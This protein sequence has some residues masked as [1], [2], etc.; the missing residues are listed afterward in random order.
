MA[1]GVEVQLFDAA[2]AA[3]ASATGLQ[4]A[5][6][7]TENVSDLSRVS[8][9]HAGATT[10]AS[11]WLRLDL[12]NQT[13]LALTQ[14]G[15]LVVYSLNAT[16]HKNSLVFA[17]K[18]QI[19]DV[20]G[21]TSTT[22]IDP[23]VRPADWLTMPTLN[24]GD[25]K[26]VGLLAV[27]ESNANFVALTCSGNYVVNW[28]DGSGDINVAAGV[29]AERN[30]QWANVGAG[31]LTSRGYRQALVTVTMQAGQTM[32]SFSLQQKHS[33][34][35]LPTTPNVAWLDC[36][37][38]APSLATLAVRTTTNVVTLNNLEVF[39]LLE[40][41]VT[42]FTSMFQFCYSLQSL[43]LL[44]TAAGTNFT[45]MFWGC[46]SLKSVPLLNTALGTNFTNMFRGCYLLQTAPLLNTASGSNF[47][48]MF[49][50]CYSLQSVPLLNTALGNTFIN[51]FYGCYALQSVPLLNTGLGSDFTS[52][53]QYCY[54]L[55]SIPL[56]NTV[57]GTNFYS[58]F[59][60]CNALQYVPLLNTALGTNFS[61]MFSYCYSLT[62]VPLLNTASGTD[63]SYMF[64]GCRS[65]QS[66]PLLNT[67]SGS[68]FSG[69][70]RDCSTLQSVPLLNTAA[71]TDF[72]SMFWGCASLQSAPLLNTAAGTIFSNMFLNC[73][74]LAKG[75]LAGTT[76][77]ISYA[78]L[79]LSASALNDIYT[80]LGTAAGAQTI[81][82]TGNWGTTSDT[83]SIATAKGWTVTG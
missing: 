62:S 30:I 5:W 46:G 18:L 32:T 54:S 10:D 76:R 38:N 8:A 56:L 21:G 11:G 80:G 66:V 51:M 1:K 9:T 42:D 48:S 14:W 7:D 22:P 75:R 60:S 67:A 12:S 24:S 55:R 26:F 52:M 65:L 43:P 23:Y 49:F 36:A 31:T 6:F 4:I 40:N 64:E 83:P 28:G 57:S 16:D 69:M 47:S 81:T 34:A 39:S 70:F 45:S 78:S 29:K 58:M 27:H 63:F 20:T 41:A 33:Q 17:S 59:Q 13:G 71:G 19:T 35:G 68:N 15:F 74:A 2:G 82:V 25:Q 37:I 73:T 3:I 77:S 61:I 79:M 44:N 72:G 50:T 53:F